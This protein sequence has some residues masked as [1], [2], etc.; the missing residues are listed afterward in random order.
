MMYGEIHSAFWETEDDS[1]DSIC[2]CV[3]VCVCVCKQCGEQCVCVCASMTNVCACASMT[4][5]CVCV[6]VYIYVCAFM[7]V[8][9][10]KYCVQVLFDISSQG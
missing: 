2:V 7:R 4:N 9:Q 8:S 10:F 1:I 5:V 6:C 3:C